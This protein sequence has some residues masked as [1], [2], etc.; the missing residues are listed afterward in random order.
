MQTAVEIYNSSKLVFGFALDQYM[1]GEGVNIYVI[2]I[3]AAFSLL[4]SKNASYT[5]QIRDIDPGK[6][7]CWPSVTDN[8]TTLKQRWSNAR[9][10]INHL[11]ASWRLR[12]LAY[13]FIE[14]SFY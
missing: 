4:T 3:S 13:V 2:V 7:Q 12:M 6:V 9:H 5:H 14:Y 10:Q 11:Q 8:R 1:E